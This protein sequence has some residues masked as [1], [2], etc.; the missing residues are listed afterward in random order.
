MQQSADEAKYTYA[1]VKF[2]SSYPD[3]KYFSLK[4]V[5][6]SKGN[7]VGGN[8]VCE[9]GLRDLYLCYRQ[10][11]I[12]AFRLLTGRILYILFPADGDT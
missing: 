4:N 12:N 2:S 6:C 8:P 11:F 10:C 1:E 5:S 9:R 3:F 7:A